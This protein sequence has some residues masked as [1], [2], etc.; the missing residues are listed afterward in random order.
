MIDQNIRNR[1]AESKIADREAYRERN[2]N[3][4]S[5]RDIDTQGGRAREKNIKKVSYTKR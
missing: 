2:S 5:Q 4:K 3:K 1:E